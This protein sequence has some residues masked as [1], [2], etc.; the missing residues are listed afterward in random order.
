MKIDSC[1]HLFLS[2][3]SQ[4]G[5]INPSP[6]I[7]VLR[8]FLNLPFCRCCLLL[9]WVNLLVC[10]WK[11][12]VEEHPASSLIMNRFF[13]TN[14]IKCFK[15]CLLRDRDFCP[16]MIILE[17]YGWFFVNVLMCSV[18]LCFLIQ[19]IP[20]FLLLS[21]LLLFLSFYS[22]LLFQLLSTWFLNLWRSFCSSWLFC[23]CCG[24]SCCFCFCYFFR[25]ELLCLKLTFFD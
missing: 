25:R 5:K 1:Q 4:A 24:Q 12:T 13:E 7:H 20:F 19:L 23:S 21:Q 15:C 11:Q 16:F 10:F 22:S 8:L 6:T 18:K 9:L 2:R 14:Q 17:S 3:L